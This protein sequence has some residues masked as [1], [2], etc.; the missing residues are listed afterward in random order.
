MKSVKKFRIF[1]G[2]FV[3]FLALMSGVG[4]TDVKAAAPKLN[5]KK[6]T[7]YVGHTEKLKVNRAKG[8]VKWTS[9]QKKIATVSS[10]GVVK[11][12]QAG[13]TTITATAGNKKL[14]CKVTSELL[15]RYPLQ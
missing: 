8:K 1:L 6:A 11:G 3:L 5:K 13:K 4:S 15:L 14:T 2:S 7:I 12:K 10:K 9:S